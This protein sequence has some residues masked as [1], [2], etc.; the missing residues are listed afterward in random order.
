MDGVPAD[1]AAV[2][3]A[4]RD[5]LHFNEWI[6]Y[7][8]NDASYS[9][10]EGAYMY[11]TYTWSELGEWLDRTE[12]VHLYCHSV[13]CLFSV[14]AGSEG[15]YAPQQVLGVGFTT[16]YVR[17]AGT[18]TW[19]TWGFNSHSVVSPDDGATLWDAS[20]AMDGDGEPS[21]LP[22][23]EVHPKGLSFA[24]YTALL[25]ADDIEIVNAGQCFVDN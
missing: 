10:Y 2:L 22:V 3:D 23:S 21:A 19:S 16:N 20:I 12:G 6:Y 5:W 4:I 25:T 7:D 8:P 11:W 17:A 14:L 1:P 18:E 15:V 13:S 24:E 9:S